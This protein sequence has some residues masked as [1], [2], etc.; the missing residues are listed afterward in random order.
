[1]ADRLKE[2][3]PDVLVVDDDQAINELVGAYAQIAG[4]PHRSAFD[5]ATALRLAHERKPALM[6]LDVML[7][8]TD[9]FKVCTAMKE[10]PTT[11][12]IPI[13]MLTAMDRD[14]CRIRGAECGATAYMT[15]P[16]DPDQLIA[17][18]R[19]HASTNGVK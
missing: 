5:G 10:D 6:V 2:D 9:G 14:E 8:D 11:R 13:L 18:I 1:M 16:F 19:K 15:K 7:P 3:R 4:F 12:S 17:A